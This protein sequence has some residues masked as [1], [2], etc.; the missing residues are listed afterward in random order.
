MNLSQ[1]PCNQLKGVGKRIS[2]RLNK[3]GIHYVQDILFHLPSRYQDRTHIQP[4]RAL[5][6]GDHVVV[7]GEVENIATPRVGRTRL[8]VS[9]R[10]LTGRIHLRFFYVTAFQLQQ[11]QIGLRVRCFGEIRKGPQG[12]EMIHPEYQTL[13]KV[14]TLPV[15]ENL[16]P[17]YPTTEG[18]SQQMIRKLTDE[19]IALLNKEGA[20]PEIIPE[21]LL[22]KLSFPSLKEALLFVHRPPS[23]AKLET[24]IEK[25]HLSQKRLVFEE[26]LAHRISL[27]H[28]KK[29]FQSQEAISLESRNTLKEKLL[30]LLPFQLT[31]AQQKVALQIQ[32][33]LTRAFPM[34]R[35]V[36]GDVGSGKTIVAALA[37]LQAIEN[38]VQAALLAPTE[39]LAEQHFNT[40]TKWFETLGVKVGLLCGH[41]KTS[42]RKKTLELIKNGEV[43]LII[44]THAI[45]QK[46]VQFKKLALIIVDEQ[47]R[48]GVEQRALLRE[49]GQELNFFPHQLIMTATPI[50]RTLAMSVYADLDYSI[51]DELPP[52]RTPVTTIVISNTRREEVLSRIREA[53]KSG[54]QAY[55]VC[56]LI[57]ESELIQC[58]A[59]EKTFA[60]LKMSLSSLT[61][62]LIHG[63]MK[64]AEKEKTMQAFKNGEMQLLIATT[65]IEVGVDVPNASLMI[66]ENAERLG[67][68][69]LHQL[70]GRVGRGALVSHCVL[71]YQNPLS[72]LAKERLAIM[73]ETT[74]GFKIAEKDLKIRGAGE[75]LGTRQTGDVGLKIADLVRDNELLPKV[76]EAAEIL[77]QEYN[78]VIEP[79]VQRWLGNKEKFGHV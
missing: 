23:H 27:M 38:G 26:L 21:G 50:P 13:D 59:A 53:C 72:H 63:R 2:E 8:Y 52:G 29:S 49:K 46:G 79:L 51:I 12:L 43:D 71:M 25:K 11:W 41:I 33:D 24:L 56:T 10:D 7:E 67:L 35:L 15:E 76:H 1:L 28:L 5:L 68:A 75:V 40:F 34:L 14:L 70:R 31:N 65:V 32:N 20:L 3:L 39:L 69:Q 37:A 42:T 18:L 74:D 19:A 60:D 77:L 55:W 62:G 47:H 17:I 57:D 64:P 78:Q 6:P 44:G 4:I 16:T 58:Q 48:F 22:K 54:R 66:I 9:L 30:A 61:I 36:Q 45:F 73:R